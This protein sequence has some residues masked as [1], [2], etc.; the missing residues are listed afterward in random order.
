MESQISKAR[1]GVLDKKMGLILLALLLFMP[2]SVLG[3]AN[4]RTSFE[5]TYAGRAGSVATLSVLHIFCPSKQRSGSGFLHKSGR[6][7]TAAHVVEGCKP[8]DVILIEAL[9]HTY[10]VAAI[11]LDREHDLALLTPAPTIKIPTLPL[12]T[13]PQFAVG[14]Q[15]TLWGYPGGYGGKAPLLTVGYLAGVDDALTPSGTAIRRYVV[16]AAFNSGNSGGPLLD[17]ATGAVIG[18]VSSKLAPVPA[19][20]EIALQTLAKQASGTIYTRTLDNGQKI[21]VSQGQ[22]IADVLQYL[23]GQT[24]LV[25]GYAV[26]LGDLQNFLKTQG[27]QP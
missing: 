21:T 27:I 2:L 14:S 15:V 4:T 24:Q 18:V 26:T 6:V 25:I 17:A 9:G 12:S 20:I 3:A 7:I 16:N 13:Q 8:S 1:C 5:A 22:L 19:H 11:A 23:R 10:N